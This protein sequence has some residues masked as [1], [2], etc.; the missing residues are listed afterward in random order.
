MS[1]FSHV[2]VDA[3]QTLKTIPSSETLARD[4]NFGKNKSAMV[5]TVTGNSV[6]FKPIFMVQRKETQTTDGRKEGRKLFLAT[7]GHKRHGDAA[8]MPFFFVVLFL[9]GCGGEFNVS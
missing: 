8:L 1:S 2:T 4:A 3:V 9:K 5:F 6:S 7:R